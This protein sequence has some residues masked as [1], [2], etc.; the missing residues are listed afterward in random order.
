MSLET[1]ASYFRYIAGLGP[2]YLGT[3]L[4]HP[5][6]PGKFDEAPGRAIAM[7]LSLCSSLPLRR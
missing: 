2:W 5:M 1:P 3:V 6:A 7:V 4:P